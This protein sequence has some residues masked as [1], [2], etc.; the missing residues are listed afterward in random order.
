MPSPFHPLNCCCVDT[1][2]TGKEILLDYGRAPEEL[3]P[4]TLYLFLLCPSNTE[5]E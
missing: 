4:K 1:V 3:W 5:M 2:L